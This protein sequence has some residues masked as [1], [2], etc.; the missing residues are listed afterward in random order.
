MSVP[1][2]MTCDKCRTAEVPLDLSMNIWVSTPHIQDP[3]RAELRRLDLC[4][5]CAIKALC[6]LSSYDRNVPYHAHR[7]LI[8]NRLV[9]FVGDLPAQRKQESS[10][11]V[12]CDGDCEACCGR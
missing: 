6:F 7:R 11:V 8:D 9:E 3:D 2:F 10:Y 1:T 4:H 12:T 5:A